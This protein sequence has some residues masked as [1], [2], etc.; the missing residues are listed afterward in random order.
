MT[1]TSFKSK[2]YSSNISDLFEEF[3]LSGLPHSQK[4]EFYPAVNIHENND[5]YE[6][7]MLV[8][9]FQKDDFK[10]QLEKDILTIGAEKK[11]TSPKEEKHYRKQEFSIASIKRSFSLPK[12]VEIE[13]ITAS[14]ENGVL[15]LKVP[16]K[17]AQ[18]EKP[19]IEIKVS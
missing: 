19:S 15:N 4:R 10:I 5:Q 3:V 7:E 16:K 17:E 8:P 1:I 13:T 9:G 12:H 14:Y 18:K 2:P 11:E 6:I